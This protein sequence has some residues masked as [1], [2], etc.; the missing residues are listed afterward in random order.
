MAIFRRCIIRVGKTYW[1]QD[2]SG[3]CV[4]LGRMSSDEA[5]ALSIRSRVPIFV[6]RGRAQGAF[7]NDSRIPR[8][9]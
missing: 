5:V 6:V 1:E 2:E 3:K 7:A 8:R 4:D 9:E